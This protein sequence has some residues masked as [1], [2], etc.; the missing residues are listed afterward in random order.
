M[1]GKLSHMH[2]ALSVTMG[3]Q[4]TKLELCLQ[5]QAQQ[6]DDMARLSAQVSK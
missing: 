1:H 2:S 4:T 5:H 3:V 6:A